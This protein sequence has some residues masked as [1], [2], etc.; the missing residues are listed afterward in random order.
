MRGQVLLMIDVRSTCILSFAML[1]QRNYTSHTIR[2]L[3]TRTCDEFGL[4]RRGFYFEKGI[5]QSSRLLKG[6]RAVTNDELT[7]TESKA[8]LRD[9]GL[10]FRHSKLPRSK[11]VERVIGQIQNLIDGGPG[12][13]GRDEMKKPFERFLERKRLVESGKA[14]PEEY[15]LSWEQ[16]EANLARACEE[17]NDARNDGPMTCGLT[18]HQAWQKFQTAPL[19]HLSGQARYLLACQKKPVRNITALVDRHEGRDNRVITF[20]D[21]IRNRARP[22][23]KGRVSVER[24]DLKDI[25]QWPVKRD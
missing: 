16:A 4:P 17:Y 20:K 22:E 24:P 14:R 10:D 21:R 3:I 25:A 1:D 15:F 5:W 13:A 11:P 12:D 6:D 23:K 2:T 9:L 18:P 7:W 8:G 19:A